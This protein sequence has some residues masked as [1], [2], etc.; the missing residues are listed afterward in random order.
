MP[1]IGTQKI[2]KE[3]AINDDMIKLTLEAL[4][5]DQLEGKTEEV[6]LN[7]DDF[8]KIKT[9]EEEEDATKIRTQRTEIVINEILLSLMRHNIILEDFDFIVKTIIGSIEQAQLAKERKLYGNNDLK[10]TIL[11]F[12]EELMN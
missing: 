6:V 10:R 12:S 9:K 11:Q 8:E 1:Y 3:E 7:K 5:I 4:A 2:I